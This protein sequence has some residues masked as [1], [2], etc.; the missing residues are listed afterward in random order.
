MSNGKLFEFVLEADPNFIHALNGMSDALNVVGRYEEAIEFCDRAL[1]ID[2]NDANTL[3]SKGDSLAYLE[4]SRRPLS[5][6]TKH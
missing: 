2:P 6:M 4:N 1:M 5:G 3:V